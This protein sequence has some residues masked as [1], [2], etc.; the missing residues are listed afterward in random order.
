MLRI[1]LLVC[2]LALAPAA[3]RAQS[4]GSPGADDFDWEVGLW[5]THVEVRGPLDPDAPWAVFDGT[6]DV[7][8]L[9]G[10][11]ANTVD[12]ALA[13]TTGARIEGVA[14]RLFSPRSSQWSINFASMNDGALTAPV[15][16]GFTEGRG[17]FHGQDTVDGRVVLVRFVISEVTGNSA[18]FVQSWSA[19][20]G[21]T[22]I[23]NWIATDTR[24]DRDPAGVH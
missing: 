1:L 14:L 21:Q 18:R 2:V 16:G 23:D 17:E 22:W 13:N 5:D 20:G 3:A 12:L 6:S 10:G 15:Y 24:R 8:P 7:R 4:S 19:D 9:S 11:R